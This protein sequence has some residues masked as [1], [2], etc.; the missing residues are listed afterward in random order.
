VRVLIYATGLTRPC[1]SCSS[2]T[3]GGLSCSAAS[4]IARGEVHSASTSIR[5][6][7]NVVLWE[8]WM[9]DINDLDT[10]DFLPDDPRLDAEWAALTAFRE[11]LGIALKGKESPT[12]S[13]TYLAGGACLHTPQNQKM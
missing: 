1:D 4:G 12:S 3:G 7:V 9:P 8:S 10:T 11:M 6:A 2:T 13:P 5:L